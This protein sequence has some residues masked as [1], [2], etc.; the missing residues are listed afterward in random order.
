MNNYY[1]LRV[2]LN[3]CSEDATDLLAAFLADEGFESFV[4]DEGGMTAYIKE[5]EYVPEKVGAILAD[6]PMDCDASFSATLVEGQDWNSEWEK[7]YFQ[8]IL[9]G[10]RVV[11]R[12]SFHHDAPKAEIEIL[13]DPRMAFG[14]GHHATTSMMVTHLLDIDVAG[15]TVTDMGTGTG[16]LAILARKLGAR[17]VAGIEIDP[18]AYENAVDNAAINETEV[19]LLC[20]DSSLLK[21]LPKADI[22]L[23]NINRNVILA[24][25]PNYAAAIKPGG[26]LI[27]SGFYEQDIP[28]ILQEA[29][30]L[31]FS[32]DTKVGEGEWRSL[33]LR[34][35]PEFKP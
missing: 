11:I 28:L 35:A 15:K 21:D 3:P 13:I 25:I 23:A 22:F 34:K 29:E 30:P 12:S 16:I 20:G 1:A 19:H 10:D 9:I 14:T 4:A 32:L 31:G 33:R 5:E 24:D 26:L 18:G 7:H 6:F 8:P 17:E 2:D 27:L